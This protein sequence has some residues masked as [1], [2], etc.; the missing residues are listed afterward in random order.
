M[1]VFGRGMR[2]YERDRRKWGD[3]EIGRQ[4]ERETRRK[5]DKATRRVS[6]KG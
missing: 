3:E 2:M 6:K 5:G 4:G 1:A